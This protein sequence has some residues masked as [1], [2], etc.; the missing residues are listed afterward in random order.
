MTQPQRVGQLFVVGVASDS[1]SA[2]LTAAIGRYHFGSVLLT[3]TGASVSALAQGSAGIQALATRQATGGVRFLVAANQEGGEIQQLDGRGFSV[4]PSALSQGRLPVAA[5]RAKA[6]LWGSQLKAAGVNLDLAPVMD[7]VPQAGAAA[8][9]PIGALDREFGSDP[10]TSGAH[11]AAFIQGLAQAGVAA[12][13]KHF[14]GLGH[15][16]GNTD[17][18]SG[19]TDT[20]TTANSPGLGSFRA[21]IGAGVRFVMVATARYTQLDASRI[22]SFSPVVIKQILRRQLGFTGVVMSDDL[23]EAAQVQAIAAGQRAVD[24]LDAGGDLIVSQDA[25]PAEAMAATVLAHA[26]A[27]P[28]F[29]S[30]VATAVLAVLTAKQAQGLLPC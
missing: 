13:A 3:K 6:A 2:G 23:G 10:A 5:L 19:V 15:V 29:G 14:P 11:G 25:G 20:V 26:D 21:A 4:M 28:S 8:N 18:T 17:F 27:A 7:V 24:F 30:E 16:A 22:A 1:A 12:T 9:A